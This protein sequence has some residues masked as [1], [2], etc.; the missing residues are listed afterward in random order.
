M[1]TLVIR[2]GLK[3][4]APITLLSVAAGLQMIGAL[5]FFRSELSTL[6]VLS[7]ALISFGIY[8]LNRFTDDEDCINCPEQKVYFQ[9]KGVLIIFP[10]LILLTAVIL[11]TAFSLLTAWH[12]L[13]II[14]GISYSV[15]LVPKV[16]HNR[17]VFFRIKDV[18][19][20]KNISVS[21]LWGV[22]P[23]AIAATTAKIHPPAL[24]LLI[25]VFSFC[26]TTFINTTSCD[27]RDIDGDKIAGVRTFAGALGKDATGIILFSISIIGSV[28]VGILAFLNYIQQT[29]VF[30]FYVTILWTLIVS[31]PI[32]FKH[33][34]L[35]KLITEPL[36]D[37]QQILC[38]V[39][40]IFISLY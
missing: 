22:I 29:T 24:D 19:I 31:T 9:N 25:V 38:G 5:L 4:F 17:L 21:L 15:A 16:K 23:F 1:N 27:V 3:I 13:L 30:L 34:H 20:L 7:Y 39:A 28:L 40:L 14:S 18:I 10:I 11:L 6:H 35:P 12:I 2:S 33:F 26:L 36:I 37:T 32:Y 8:L